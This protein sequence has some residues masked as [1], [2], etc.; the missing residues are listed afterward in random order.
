MEPI[1]REDLRNHNEVAWPDHRFQTDRIVLKAP[2]K[3]HSVGGLGQTVPSERPDPTAMHG[4]YESPQVQVRGQVSLQDR[5]AMFLGPQL[6]GAEHS[7]P[8][9]G[10]AISEIGP[11]HQVV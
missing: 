9:W 5:H 1:R 4:L 8:P 2:R 7:E 6:A 10:D 11:F 3:P